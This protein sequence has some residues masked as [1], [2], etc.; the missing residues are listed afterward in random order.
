[1]DAVIYEITLRDTRDGADK[2]TNKADKN[3]NLRELDI[4]SMMQI[5]LQVKSN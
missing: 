2:N 3:T 1:M 4:R 5:T